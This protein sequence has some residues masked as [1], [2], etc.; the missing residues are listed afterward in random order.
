MRIPPFQE[1]IARADIV[2]PDERVTNLGGIAVAMNQ[3]PLNQEKGRS[4]R[5]TALHDYVFL[6]ASVG[7]NTR[8]VAE[9][10]HEEEIKIG[11]ARDD[12]N[13]FFGVPTMAASVVQGIEETFIPIKVRPDWGGIR[14]SEREMK[15]L[16]RIGAGRS[17]GW[18]G[19]SL[20]CPKQQLQCDMH[21]LWR[22]IG[23]AGRTHG[24]RRSY[25]L[26]IFELSPGEANAQS[27][28]AG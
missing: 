21:N 16:R 3:I 1:R 27:V 14:P 4:L 25:E 10:L 11:K 7:G 26:R 17:N 12:I 23:A 15:I 6:L 22:R 18:I 20:G 5:L 9:T 28:A 24:M 2:L 19:K 13:D 8:E